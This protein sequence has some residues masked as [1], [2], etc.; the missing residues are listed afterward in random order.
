[1]LER[2]GF[3]LFLQELFPFLVTHSFGF[4]LNERANI[5]SALTEHVRGFNLD[6]CDC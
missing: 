3:C 2:H 6:D 4:R 1:M 5:R